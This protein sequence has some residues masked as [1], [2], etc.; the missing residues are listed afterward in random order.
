MCVGMDRDMSDSEGEFVCSQ[1]SNLDYF[2]I[3]SA[4]FG[5]DIVDQY[6][7]GDVVSL[8][9]SNVQKFDLGAE[10]LAVK[11]GSKVVYGNVLIEDISSEEEVSER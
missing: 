4:Y 5:Q 8:E 11:E 3:R 2:Q 6:I 10:D 7:E 1:V 9:N